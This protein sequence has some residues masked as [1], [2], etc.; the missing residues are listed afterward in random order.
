MK[1]YIRTAT[2]D[3]QLDPSYKKKMGL[4]Q[5]RSTSA[6]ILVKLS[7]DDDYYIRYDVAKNTSTPSTTLAQLAED[8]V[9]L[10]RSAVA[11][12][13]ST[14]ADTLR[15]LAHDDSNW[16]RE[17]VAQNDNTPRDVVEVL[18]E[19]GD[20]EVRRCAREKLGDVA[21]PSKPSKP[22]RL[23]WPKLISQLRREAEDGIDSLYEQT[24]AGDEI[25]SLCTAVENKLGIWLEPSIQGGQ[26]GIWFYSSEDDSTLASDYDYQT[27][28]EN[29]LGLALQSKNVTEFRNK[30]R[31]FVQ[32]ILDDP[33][34]ATEADE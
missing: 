11:G 26:G 12:N 33:A 15:Q 34:Y 16:V 21:S 24:S 1:R 5:D 10:V 30:Y 29:V 13:A 32:S 31:S 2:L 8:S 28:N 22:K 7:T 20:I 18:A 9:G 4:A 14:P 6:E 27:Y 25:T 23:S 17:Q 3:E 19:D